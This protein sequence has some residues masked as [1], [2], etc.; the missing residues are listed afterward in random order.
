MTSDGLLL[1]FLVLGMVL[2]RP[3]GKVATVPDV[4]VPADPSGVRLGGF[5]G[6]R[7]EA[8]ARERLVLVDEDELVA[9]FEHR[10]GSHPWIGEHVGKWLTAACMS[11]HGN[12]DAALAAK[13]QRVARRLMAAQE[14][15]GYLGTYLSADRFQLKPGADWDVWVHK[16]AIL[17]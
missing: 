17:G 13:I 1:T 10:P 16:Y 7:V 14:Q 9:G 11:A 15:D 8:S 3:H 12:G 6:R 5:L 4:L 2:V